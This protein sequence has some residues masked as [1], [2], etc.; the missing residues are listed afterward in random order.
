MWFKK[1]E[2]KRPEQPGLRLKF[3]EGEKM[4]WKGI[5]FTVSKVE[6]NRI[7]LTPESVT[8]KRQK[9]MEGK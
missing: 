3:K 5:W 7:E 8:W 9:L 2:E 4:P 1:K 6:F